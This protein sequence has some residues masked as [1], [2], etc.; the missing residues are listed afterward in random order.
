MLQHLEHQTFPNYLQQQPP[1]ELFTHLQPKAP[2][3][4]LAEPVE[5]I[6]QLTGLIAYQQKNHPE[7]AKNK[8]ENLQELINALQ[9]YE[10]TQENSILR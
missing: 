3:Y 6:L 10:T 1:E 5:H 8:L 4:S 9:Q 7:T 2:H